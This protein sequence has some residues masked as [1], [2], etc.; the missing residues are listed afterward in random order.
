LFE[1]FARNGAQILHRGRRGD[2]RQQRLQGHL[3]INGLL[4]HDRRL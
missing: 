1:R 4:T 2:A 3:V